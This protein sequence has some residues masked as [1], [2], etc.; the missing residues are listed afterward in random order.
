M[1]MQTG[2]RWWKK[3]IFPCLLLF[4][5]PMV[6]S[7]CGDP[8]E[9]DVQRRL[10]RTIEG[11]REHFRDK[12]VDDVLRQATPKTLEVPTIIYVRGGISSASGV[13]LLVRWIEKYPTPD[14]LL[15]RNDQ[16]GYQKIFTIPQYYVDQN[17][18]DAKVT[19]HFYSFW[20]LEH[21]SDEWKGLE[22]QLQNGEVTA[23][24]LRDGKP[25]SNVSTFERRS[26]A[27]ANVT[28]MSD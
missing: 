11:N 3:S 1:K 23:V 9:R 18:E 2:L 27:R 13:A 22:P 19:I 16:T 10:E 26:V 14:A 28:P 4:S 5:I 6:C 25:V 24:L 12:D 20:R 21:E 17:H 7:G 8:E 15:L